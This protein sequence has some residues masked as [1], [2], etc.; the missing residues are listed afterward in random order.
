MSLTSSL[1]AGAKSFS[2]DL[3]QLSARALIGSLYG[4]TAGLAVQEALAQPGGLTLSFVFAFSLAFGSV[5]RVTRGWTLVGIGLF[6][7]VS[8]LAG[9]L[10]RLYVLV[11]PDA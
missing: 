11:A 7:L 4:V 3:L 10:L 8:V 9:L 5:W 2:L 1:Q 6:S